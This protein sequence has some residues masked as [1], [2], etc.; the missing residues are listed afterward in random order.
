LTTATVRI[1]GLPRPIDPRRLL[2]ILDDLAYAV[3]VHALAHRMAALSPHG[4]A[5]LHYCE[6]WRAEE[7][8]YRLAEVLP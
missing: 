6:A 5:G 8:Y 1:V 2:P 7:I 4:Q 3:R